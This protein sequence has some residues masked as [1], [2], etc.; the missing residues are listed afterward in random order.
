MLPQQKQK[1]AAL[2][3]QA[4][5]GLGVT[6]VPVVLERPKVES[7]GDVACNVA[8]QV[9]K[10]LRR[11]PREIGQ[12]IADALQV[13]PAAAGLVAAAEVAGP[14]FVNV[15]LT[16]RRQAGGRA[17]GLARGRMLSARSRCTPASA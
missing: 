10:S 6:G 9:A 4:L 11:N 7:H 2:I 13:N 5:A 3:E 15:R 16:A 1:I 17:A 12:A 8:M 14:G